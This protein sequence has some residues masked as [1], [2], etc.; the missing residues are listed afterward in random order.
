MATGASGWG[1]G[2]GWLNL[3]MDGNMD[4]GLEAPSSFDALDDFQRVLGHDFDDVELLRRAL[5]HPSY[6]NEHP[7]KC[8]DDNQR[9]EFLGDAVLDF[10]AGAWVYRHY[11][12][13]DEGKM[14]RLRA[15]LVRTEALAGL[16]RG[17]G[18]GEAL[19]LGR[20]E[21]EA[22]G[23]GRDAILCDSFEAVVGALY[24][25]GGTTVVQAFVEPLIGPVA[26][27]ILAAET[28][29]DAKSKLQEWSQAELGTTPRYRIAAEQGPDHLKIFE[30]E[31]LL[32]DQVAGR[33]TG[34]SKQTAEQAAARAA[35]S[36]RTHCRPAGETGG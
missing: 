19:L 24:L 1:P 9:L 11:P 28:D 23:R 36:S 32:G 4:C 22:G 5:T 21:R 33:G 17:V 12:E 6:F 2:V 30:A 34:K 20:G 16:A 27:A 14:T 7:E 13:F 25:D 18:V 15:A 3:L 26:A 31:V 8:T 10:V 29:W 35:W